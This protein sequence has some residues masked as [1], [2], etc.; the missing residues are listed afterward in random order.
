MDNFIKFDVNPNEF[1]CVHYKSSPNRLF[2][3]YNII[4]PIITAE[5]RINKKQ[6]FIEITK[7]PIPSD[8]CLRIFHE[9]IQ[10]LLQLLNCNGTQEVD[11]FVF[12]SNNYK[13]NDSINIYNY[14][15]DNI[16]TPRKNVINYFEKIYWK[17]GTDTSIDNQIPITNST[18]HIISENKEIA[19]I[20]LKSSI[21][22]P[23]LTALLHIYHAHIENFL[24]YINAKP[25]DVE[26]LKNINPCQV[27]GECSLSYVLILYNSTT[28]EYIGHAVA[29]VF[30]EFI[31]IYDVSIKDKGKGYGK[32]IIDFIINYTQKEFLWLG[33]MINN[34][35]YKQAISLY[36]NFNFTHPHIGN[37]TLGQ[38]TINGA[39]FISLLHIKNSDFGH[40]KDYILNYIDNIKCFKRYNIQPNILKEL[41]IL[42]SDPYERGGNLLVES[43][44]TDMITSRSEENNVDKIISNFKGIVNKGDAVSFSTNTPI[45]H[46]VIVQPSEIM[47]HTHP[48]ACYKDNK[49]YL[50]W[51]SSTDFSI[52]ISNYNKSRMHL[53]ITC[54]GVYIINVTTF[55]KEFIE[56][57][58]NP[59]FDIHKII[60]DMVANVFGD[61]D[62]KRFNDIG[63]SIQRLKTK[64]NLSEFEKLE[65]ELFENVAFLISNNLPFSNFLNLRINW[66]IQLINNYTFGQLIEANKNYGL[67]TE[68]QELLKTLQSKSFINNLKLFNLTFIQ[69][70]DVGLPAKFKCIC[71]GDCSKNMFEEPIGFKKIIFEKSEL[72]KMDVTPLTISVNTCLEFID[73]PIPQL[74]PMNILKSATSQILPPTKQKIPISIKMKMKSSKRRNKEKDKLKFDFKY[75]KK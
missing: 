63:S 42:L 64:D 67:V 55:L 28:R 47:F 68:V 59:S 10:K 69:W 16:T 21:Y 50:G 26:K 61:F 58:K 57:F 2:I 41:Y 9:F 49:C 25:E 33:V 6:A 32:Y 13:L 5:V 11:N 30:D 19:L 31:E 22:T 20:P 45:H 34:P 73:P 14:L 7:I 4:G 75:I 35:D 74:L 70:A 43:F 60:I 8:N 18:K 44:D 71:V 23:N 15:L 52:V 62:T 24:S 36:S 17:F 54:E 46:S 1:I 3:Y 53:V 27:Y 12:S 48:T 66:F 29:I 37:T 39:Q 72:D 38:L 65:L 51:P 56:E 40:K